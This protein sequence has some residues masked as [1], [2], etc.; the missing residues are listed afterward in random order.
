MLVPIIIGV[1]A[2]AAG[3]TA[4]ERGKA[5]APPKDGGK[6]PEGAD[7][8]KAPEKSP[9]DFRKEGREAALAEVKAERDA[10]KKLQRAVRAAMGSRRPAPADDGGDD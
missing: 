1:L 2:L 7:K 10:Q 5:K 9:D 4:H 3:A 6:A 8:T